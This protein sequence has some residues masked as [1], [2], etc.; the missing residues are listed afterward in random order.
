MSV[1]SGFVVK[2]VSL[3]IFLTS[4]CADTAKPASGNTPETGGATVSTDRNGVAMALRFG[5]KET[6]AEQFAAVSNFPPLLEVQC[7]STGLSDDSI[8]LLKDL[9]K[10]EVIRLDATS[11]T[12]KSIS[13]L[14]KLPN[15]R[16][17][18]LTNSPSVDDSVIEL[19]KGHPTLESL[20]VNG[21]TI[22]VR[23]SRVCYPSM[24]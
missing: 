14:T 6:T 8:G 12:S 7:K 5:D 16:E 11:A 19:L 15:L 4:G 2:F 22:S 9:R 23:V 18:E 3:L 13:M 1:K 21:S 17:L 20:N 10:L 24:A